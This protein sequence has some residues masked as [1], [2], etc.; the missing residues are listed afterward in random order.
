M[1][2][3]VS[4]EVASFS[5]TSLLANLANPLLYQS[6]AE[7]ALLG[8]MLVATAALLG[9]MWWRSQLSWGYAFL[10][11]AGWLIFA[12]TPLSAFHTP[13]RVVLHIEWRYALHLWLLLLAGLV[14]LA[15]PTLIMIWQWLTKGRP[16]EFAVYGCVLALLAGVYA[17]NQ[18]A[19]AGQQWQDKAKRFSQPLNVQGGADGYAHVYD[20]VQRNLRGA[21]IWYDIAQHYYLYDPA[22]TNQ[23]N[24]GFKYPLGMP[25][26]QPYF[27]PDYAVISAAKGL[28]DEQ[29]RLGTT[30]AWEVLYDDGVFQ[31]L[32]RLQPP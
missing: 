26:S 1:G 14:I 24:A 4:P 18:R 28:A 7:S 19:D 5:S 3:Y 32:R 11:V 29:L 21:R 2:T 8:V 23:P 30:Y 9:V 16:G 10:V 12:A 13:Q 27:I 25:Q 6:G 31:V 17:F 15:A 20:Y 22:Y